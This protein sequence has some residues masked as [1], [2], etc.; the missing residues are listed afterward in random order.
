MGALGG[1][2]VGIAVVGI[3]PVVS[4]ILVSLQVLHLELCLVLCLLCLR[5]NWE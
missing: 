5:S 2:L 3:I 4:V 1:L